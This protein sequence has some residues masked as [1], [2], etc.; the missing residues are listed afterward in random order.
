MVKGFSKAII[1]GNLTRDPE[2]RTTATGMSVTSF[3]VAIN[4]T[5]RGT[6]GDMKDDVS[7]IDC[8]AWGKPGETIAKYLRRGS[9]ILL[10]GRLS[11]HTWDD[12]DSGA[13]RS[14]TEITVEDFN[15]VGGRED[16]EYG[17]MP[18]MPAKSAGKKPASKAA[19]EDVLPD[20]VDMSGADEIDLDGVP[21]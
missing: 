13:K 2:T 11:Q 7:Y 17:G 6:D 15:F 12:K 9:A 8:S 19:Q 18:E 1:M 5:Y 4:R 21:F 10:S 3:S 16:G 14:R 20:E